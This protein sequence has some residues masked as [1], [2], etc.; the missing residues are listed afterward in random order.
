MEAAAA[1]VE[2]DV[3]DVRLEQLGRPLAGGLDEQGRRPGDRGAAEL[4]GAGPDR[5]SAGPDEVGVAMD[6]M[7]PLQR[8]ARAVGDDHRP[9]RVV[10]L[11]E[12]CRSAAHEQV[13]VIGELHGGFLRRLHHGGDLDIGGESD[14]EGDTAVGAPTGGLLGAQLVVTGSIEGAAQ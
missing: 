6:D 9:R 10:A 5:E 12:R 14:A 11:S 4:D 8:D 7:D 1:G 2:H 3:G 13:A